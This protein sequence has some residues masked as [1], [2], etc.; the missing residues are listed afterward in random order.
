[1]K[2]YYKSPEEVKKEIE[3]HIKKN[4][5]PTHG[6]VLQILFLNIIIIVITFLILDKSG[7]LKKV[8]QNK[9]LPEVEYSINGN[10]L[11]LFFKTKKTYILVD[12]QTQPD[13][14]NIIQINKIEIYV[15]QHIFEIYP[16]FPKI[17]VDNIQNQLVIPLEKEI[18]PNS[19]SKLVMII[20]GQRKE[21]KKSL[22]NNYLHY[23][24]Q[25]NF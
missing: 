9:F 22:Q 21:I 12:S 11:N 23:K 3:E 6:R 18:E 17:I 16:Q 5:A 7:I 20:N 1:M 25:K 15:N 2:Y 19:V 10:N 13:M 24:N 14:E 4:R 8:Y